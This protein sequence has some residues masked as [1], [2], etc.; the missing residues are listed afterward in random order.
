MDAAA[1]QA[2]DEARSKLPA[3]VLLQSDMPAEARAMCI[4]LGLDALVKYKTEKDQAMHVKK[5]LEEWNGAMW[6]VIIGQSY[7]ASVAHENHALVVFR[8]G[9]VKFLCFQAYDEGSLINT[10]KEVARGKRQ[11]KKEE[12]GGAAE[13][14]AAAAAAAEPA[15]AAAG[16]E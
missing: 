10:K 12:E 1:K 8:V 6:M 15:A 4:T 16:A 2:F 9:R 5:A 11:E 13:P 3:P 7:G 14:A